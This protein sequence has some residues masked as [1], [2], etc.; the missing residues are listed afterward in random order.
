M[1]HR[2]HRSILQQIKPQAQIRRFGFIAL[3]WVSSHQ[4][5]AGQIIICFTSTSP[6][7]ICY[8]HGTSACVVKMI[9]MELLTATCL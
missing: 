2:A 3:S 1:L 5:P 6:A 9:E 8:P 4:I 7:Q